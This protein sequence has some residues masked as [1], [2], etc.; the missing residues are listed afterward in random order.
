MANLSPVVRAEAKTSNVDHIAGHC[1]EVE[2]KANE[3]SGGFSLRQ[4]VGCYVIIFVSANPSCITPKLI[5][6]IPNRKGSLTETL[7][8][9]LSP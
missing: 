8:P 9:Q 6:T 4:D 3:K 5:H 1:Y 2:E 7:R